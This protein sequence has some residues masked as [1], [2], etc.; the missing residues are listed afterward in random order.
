[1]MA[2]SLELA[3]VE[4]PDHVFFKSLLPQLRSPEAPLPYSEIYG[5]YLNRQRAI[6][7]GGYKLIQYPKIDVVRL[8]HLAQDPEEM[9]DLADDPGHQGVRRDLEERLRRLQLT[10]DDPLVR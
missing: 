3:G 9:R 2:T 4:K 5:A 1:M 10:M 6:V 8:Y 7:H